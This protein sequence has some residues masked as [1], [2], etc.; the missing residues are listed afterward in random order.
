[1][2]LLKTELVSNENYIVT[3]VNKYCK[4]SLILEGY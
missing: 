1:M 3:L 4:K 2:K